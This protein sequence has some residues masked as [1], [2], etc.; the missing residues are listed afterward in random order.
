[1]DPVAHRPWRAK[2][3]RY[4]DRHVAIEG[5]VPSLP[6]HTH[7]TFADLLDETVVEQVLAGL[8]RHSMDLRA[9]RD[10]LDSGSK[11][12]P[13]GGPVL[14]IGAGSSASRDRT[15]RV[16]PGQRGRSTCFM[17]CAED[18][19]SAVRVCRTT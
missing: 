13:G 1:M 6:H 3:G 7:P 16:W 9:E 10:R 2:P 19:V 4:L 18:R 14:S 15:A 5:G 17:V 12:Y 11:D 8:E